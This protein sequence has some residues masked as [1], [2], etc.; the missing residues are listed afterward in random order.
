MGRYVYVYVQLHVCLHIHGHPRPTSAVIPSQALSPDPVRWGS[1]IKTGSS[2]VMLG[3][4]GSES[5]ASAYLCL[6]C[7]GIIIALHCW[8][9]DLNR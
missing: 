7:A 3:W 4:L 6:P 8:L 5:Q 1:Y 9:L 2:V